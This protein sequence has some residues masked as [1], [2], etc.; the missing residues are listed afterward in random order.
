[1]PVR[2]HGHPRAGLGAGV[3]AAGGGGEPP[4]GTMAGCRGSLGLTPRA[5]AVTPPLRRTM[6]VGGEPGF[7]EPP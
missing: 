7:D 3:C 6:L 2:P 4:Q 5:F 1:M